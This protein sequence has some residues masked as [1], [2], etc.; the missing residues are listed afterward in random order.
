[1]VTNGGNADVARV[2]G[3]IETLKAAKSDIE[4]RISALEAQLRE[5]N[6]TSPKT[7]PFL[8]LTSPE[9]S[10]WKCVLNIEALRE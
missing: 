5:T 3:E 6:V 10:K 1:M 9:S 8:S 4:S 2:L 7:T